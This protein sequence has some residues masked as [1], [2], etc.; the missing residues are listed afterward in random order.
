[1]AGIKATGNVE[2]EVPVEIEDIEIK[3]Y[4]ETIKIVFRDIAYMRLYFILEK[5][6]ALVFAK[7]LAKAC[8]SKLTSPEE[9]EGAEDNS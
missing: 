1:M 2:I 6:S 9:A 4:G 7:E 8:G 5:D 3:N